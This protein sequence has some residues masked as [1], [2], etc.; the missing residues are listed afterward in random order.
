M[1]RER[2]REREREMWNDSKMI[3]CEKADS[4]LYLS[5]IREIEENFRS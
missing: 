4:Y 5:R 2:E 1:L 3:E